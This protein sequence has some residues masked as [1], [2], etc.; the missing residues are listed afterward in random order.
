MYDHK[1]AEAKISDF[2]EKKRIFEKSLTSRPKNKQYVFYDGPPFATGLPHYGHILGLTSKDLF[3]RFWTMRGWRVERRWGWDCHGLPIENFAEKE[4]NIKEK[5]QVEEMGVKEFNEFCRSK[6]LGF[7][8]EWKKTVRRMGKWIEFDNAYKTMDRDYMESVWCILKKLYDEGYLYE[9]KKI[10]LYCSRC[11]TPLAASEI[12]MDESYKEV[13]EKAATVKFQVKDEK[14]TFFLAWT[15]TPWTLIGNVA[16]AVNPQLAY[17]KIKSGN[18]F[19]ILARDR[20]FSLTKEHE[21]VGEVKGEKLLQK[22]YIPL[23]HI[24]SEKTG[25]YVINGGEQVSAEEGTGIVHLALYGE[26]DYEMIKK[27]NLPFIQHVGKQGKV[28]LGPKE[29]LGVWFKKADEK[30]LEDLKKRNL[31]FDAEEHPHNYP[32]C[33]RCGTPLFY[34]ALDSWFINIQKVKK[35]LLEKNEE[36]E[37]HPGHL[38]YGR[39]KHV[40]ETAPDWAISRNRFWATAIPI[41]KCKQCRNTAVIGSVRELKQK[42]VEKI[43]DDID[44]HKHVMDSIHLR[45]GECRGQMNRIPDVLDCWVESG[46]M[47]FAAKHYPFE[48]KEWFSR[49][50]P[51]DFIS[52]YIGQVRTWFYYMHALSVILFDKPAFKNV[53]VT[54]NVLAADGSKMSKSKKNFPD[55]HELFDRYGADALRFYL[56]SSPLMRAED[57]NFNEAHVRETYRKVIMLCYNVHQFYMMHAT[58]KRDNKPA[59]NCLLDRWIMSR[60]HTLIR[61]ATNALERYNTITT[62]NEIASFVNDLSL[63]YVRRSRDRFSSRDQKEKEDAVETLGHI[64]LTLAKVMA[65]IAPFITEEIY[66]QRKRDTKLL[67]SVHLEEWPSYDE[68][69]ISETVEKNMRKTREVVSMALE[70]RASSAIPV[71]QVLSRL[72]VKGIDLA[73]EYFQLIAEE[74][75]VK[76]VRR[77]KGE[78]L[79]VKVDTLLT[80]GL[81]EEGVVREIIRRIQALRKKAGLQKQDKITLMIEATYNLQEH[82]EEIKGKV[83]AK[84]ITFGKAEEDSLSERID[85]RGVRVLVS[86][87]KCSS[88]TKEKT[89]TKHEHSKTTTPKC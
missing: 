26:F 8:Q 18:E 29:F 21:V 75:N 1:R 34:N 40:L 19:F 46:S 7:A 78:K 67:E 44:L 20:L 58:G 36:I 56:M 11:E 60:L 59:R 3:P 66:Q 28:H 61:N 23:Y 89:P 63:W 55:P 88:S 51:S 30:V 77:G 52:E 41:W 68:Q 80:P 42:A 72:D 2:W 69:M 9:G 53:L 70:Q 16:L 74:V 47:P 62:C 22:R 85:I 48:N 15:T 50:S 37:W 24:P 10:L 6:V 13:R 14:D 25:H 32:F 35:K 45:C 86:L 87:K 38:K 81:E 76:E 54:G 5:K 31:L 83:G 82:A 39:F 65:P 4:L 27:Y 17:V 84:T 57:L 49:N 12:A 71:R 43:S 79:E 33:Y 73:E 64:I